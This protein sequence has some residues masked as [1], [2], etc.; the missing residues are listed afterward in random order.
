MDP[1]TELLLMPHRAEETAILANRPPP[2]ACARV[3]RCAQAIHRALG[4]GLEG[5][6]YARALAVELTALRIAFDKDAFFDVRYRGVTVGKRRVSFLLDEAG[7]DVLAERRDPEALRLRAAALLA[8]RPVG[9]A[10][11][12][13]GALLEASRADAPSTAGA[14]SRPRRAT[15]VRERD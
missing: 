11:N 9:L 7:V 10:I 4:P 13:N 15:G 3:L 12:F 14:P 6:L 5:A 8:Y 1:D 2:D